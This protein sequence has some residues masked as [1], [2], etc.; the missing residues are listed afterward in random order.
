[1][2]HV[3]KVKEY[4]RIPIFMHQRG[5]GVTQRIRFLNQLTAHG[6]KKHEKFDQRVYYFNNFSQSSR[7]TKWAHL[8]LQDGSSSK[9]PIVLGTSASTHKLPSGL[10]WGLKEAQRLQ[11]QEHWHYRSHNQGSTALHLHCFLHLSHLGHTQGRCQPWAALG[12]GWGV[13]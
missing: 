9:P 3:K 13:P 5:Y 2:V 10:R 1:M 4:D 6:V 11:L 12:L 8:T 7:H